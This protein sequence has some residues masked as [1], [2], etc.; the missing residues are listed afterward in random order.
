MRIWIGSMAE[1]IVCLNASIRLL[2]VTSDQIL[3]VIIHLLFSEHSGWRYFLLGHIVCFLL[4]T[5]H[6]FLRLGTSTLRVLFNNL[7]HFWPHSRWF[8]QSICISTEIQPQIHI[9]VINLKREKKGYDIFKIYRRVLTVWSAEVDPGEIQAN[10]T[11]WELGDLLKNESRNTKVSLDP[12]KGTWGAPLSIERIHS[13]NA[14]RL[15]LISAP[16]TLLYFEL[17]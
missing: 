13:F 10:M 9:L 14:R 1:T 8:F 11:M 6:R 16:S 3:S 15:L 12:R 4:V 2:I 17:L 7:D 5:N